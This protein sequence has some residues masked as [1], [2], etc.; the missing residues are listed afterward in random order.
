MCCDGPVSGFDPTVRPARN[1]AHG[2]TSGRRPR[3]ATSAA[4]AFVS[5]TGRVWTLCSLAVYDLLVG[6]RAWSEERYLAWLTDTLSCQ[7]IGANFA[8]P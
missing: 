3:Q 1:E 5:W 8:E 4:S 6:E 7:L 2:R